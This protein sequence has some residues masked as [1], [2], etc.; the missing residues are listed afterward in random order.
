MKRYQL[1]HF[2]DTS[3]MAEN[4]AYVL[5]GD[6]IES[7]T[8]NFNPE[9]ETKQWIHQKDGTT[10]LK[11]YTPSFDV[12]RQDCV[13]DNCRT[14]IKRM[15]NELPTGAEA[16]TYV[17]RVDQTDQVEESGTPVA[18]TYVAYRR[19]FTVSATSTGGDAGG[20]VVDALNFGGVGDQVKGKFNTS[21]LTFTPDA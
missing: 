12:E 14:W 15:I 2:V 6:G 1:S 10:T 3:M 7:L 18:N 19:I 16:R 11:S 17:V 9:T 5:L 21:T 8:E 4:S 13:D 20:D